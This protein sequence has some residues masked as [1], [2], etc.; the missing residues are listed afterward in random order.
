MVGI[1]EYI[2]PI[3]ANDTYSLTEVNGPFRDDR[4]D[5]VQPTKLSPGQEFTITRK[6]QILNRGMVGEETLKVG[7]SRI[8]RS[9]KWFTLLD[10][11]VNG[12]GE[13]VYKLAVAS[14]KKTTND[15]VVSITEVYP[16][17]GWGTHTLFQRNW[18]Q[19]GERTGSKI[20]REGGIQA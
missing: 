10:A 6:L 12:E 16:E 3:D 9:R 2:P 20:G 1:N 14:D 4:L 7:W 18:Y 5:K 19:V 11:S 17:P 15:R 8:E 13:I